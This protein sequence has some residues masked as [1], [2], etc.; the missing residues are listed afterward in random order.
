MEF[1]ESWQQSDQTCRQ[2]DPTIKEYMNK[3]AALI[4][5]L[6]FTT[7]NS[8]SRQILQE[9]DWLFSVSLLFYVTILKSYRHRDYY[10]EKNWLQV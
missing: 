4:K 7:T 5:R 2:F 10:Y 6:Q 1:H 9:K 3:T 8:N